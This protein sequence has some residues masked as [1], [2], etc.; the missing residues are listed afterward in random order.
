MPLHLIKLAVGAES[1][2]DLREWMAERM[3]EARRRRAPLRHAHVTRMTP[4]R[5]EQILDGGSLYWVVKG[6]ISA[7]QRI[8]GLEP[9]VDAGGIG[10]C[11]IWLDQTVV[12][13]TPRPMRA[14][15][16]WRYYEPKDAPPD[17]DEAEP[18]FA[19]MPDG[20]RRDLASLGLI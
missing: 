19:A 2:T 4:E 14:F 12:S 20:M 17:I 3:A 11:K 7:R 16:G 15:Q 6:L 9:F 1:L 13:V 18:G 8:V 10:R 5:T